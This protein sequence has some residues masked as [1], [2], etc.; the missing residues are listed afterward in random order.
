MSEQW[1]WQCERA[2]GSD[3]VAGRQILNEVLAH[4]EAAHWR[5]HDIFAV[6]LAM[7][8]ALLNAI[9]HGNHLDS[10]KQ[11]HVVCEISAGK[12]RI[13]ITDEGAGFDPA[14]LADPTCPERL[15]HPGG[16]G[17]MLMRAFMTRVQYSRTG[18]RVVLEKERSGP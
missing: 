16:R 7:E 4:L 18:N 8:E 14:A 12:I 9:Q 2:I 1:L 3:A 6:H 11:I 15:Q 13:E 10:S 5:Q 17:V